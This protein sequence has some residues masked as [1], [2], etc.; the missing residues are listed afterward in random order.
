MN[1]RRVGTRHRFGLI[2]HLMTTGSHILFI[3]ALWYKGIR[4]P[5]TPRIPLQ[6]NPEVGG[7][8]TYPFA[9]GKS[10]M[11]KSEFR[12]GTLI[13][14]KLEIGDI[15]R[16]SFITNL[17]SSTPLL[18]RIFGCDCQPLYL[19]PEFTELRYS[20]RQPLIVH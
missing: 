14:C 15:I 9:K 5:L 10:Q 11:G 7:E 20:K 13:P 8:L 2:S 17:E 16:W 6:V 4:W 1:I 3:S 19:S 18:P 12:E